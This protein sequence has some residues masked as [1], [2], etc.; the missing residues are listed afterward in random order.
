MIKELINRYKE[1]ISYL[2]FGV[3]TT[4]VNLISYKFFTILQVD[5]YVSVVLAW[6]LSVVFAFITN[7]LFV[8]ESKSWKMAILGKELVLFLSAR[9]LSLGIDLVAMGL[10]VNIIHIQDMIAKLV[11]NVI[12]VIA[13]YI[14][15]KFLIF[16]K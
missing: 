6:I 4:I 14:F 8:F 9:I 3:L 13:N 7:K 10:M 1:A 12:V 15:S 2:L 5:L 11:A 16:K